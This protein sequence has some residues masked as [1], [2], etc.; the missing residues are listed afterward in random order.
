[1]KQDKT[2]RAELMRNHIAGF[3]QSKMKVEAYCNQHQ[4]KVH[5]FY[6]GQKK[7]Q[8]QQAGKFISITPVLSNTPVTILFT[9]GTQISFT[10]LP[11]VGYVKQLTQ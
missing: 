4:I 10:T 7:L 5:Q 3:K 9:N 11:P 6:Y 1:M 2:V 8:P